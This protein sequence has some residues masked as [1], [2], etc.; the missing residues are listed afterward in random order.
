MKHFNLLF[1]QI[2]LF[3]FLT[4][5]ALYAVSTVDI[6]ISDAQIVEGN[7]GTQNLVFT[8]TKGGNSA[9]TGSVSWKIVD[10][11]TTSDADYINDTGTISDI[12]NIADP[13]I[14]VS[15]KGDTIIEPNETFKVILYNPTDDAKIVDSEGIGTIVDNEDRFYT[16]T[17]SSI[18]VSE[19]AGTIS[20][21]VR[22][23]PAITN[24]DVIKVYYRTV[25][26]T[27]TA[28]G[29][30][31]AISSAIATID[32]S[33]TVNGIT[34]FNVN[35]NIVNDLISESQEYFELVLSNPSITT[36]TSSTV[37]LATDPGTITINDDDGSKAVISIN[38][39][40]VNEGDSG[41]NNM[42]FTISVSQI[43][44]N[45]S[46]SFNYATA[47]VTATSGVDFEYTTGT[48]IIPA[49][50]QSITIPVP[51]IGDF[52]AGEG[53]EELKMVISSASSLVDM[54]KDVGIGTIVDNDS[55]LT[56]SINDASIA[57]TDSDR[58]VNIDVRFSQALTQDLNLTY[59]S[60]DI[61]AN[62]PDDYNGT[63]IPSSV[64]VPAGSLKYTIQYTIVGDDTKEENEEF[65][66]EINATSSEPFVLAR[67][68][69]KVTI[70]DDDNGIGCSSY[71]G[72]MTINEYQN[73]PNYKDDNHPL[74]NNAGM[75]PGNYVEIKYLDFL[76]KQY[77]N[78]LWGV[79][80]HTTAGEHS[81]TWNQRDLSCVDPRYEVFQMNNNVMGKEGYVVLTDQNGN[82]VD[83]LNIANSNHYTQ[84]CHDFVY[85]TDFLSSAQNKDLFREPDGTGDWDDNG[86]GAN[87]G[88]SRCINKDG[89][90]GGLLF[91]IFDAIDTG[92]TPTTPIISGSSVPIMTKI[93]NQA[94][95]L[96]ILSLEP[97]SGF[98][99][100]SEIKVR[101][102]LADGITG[103]RLPGADTVKNP[104]KEVIFNNSSTQPVPNYFYPNAYKN[105]RLRFEYCG[106]DAGAYDDWTEC[107][108][109]DDIISITN[110]RISHSRDNFAI[111]PDHF[112]TTNLD[113]A[114]LKAGSPADLTFS[115]IDGDGTDTV[116]YNESQGTSFDINISVGKRTT[117][118]VPDITMTPAIAF[119]DGT[120]ND[121]F[122][123]NDIGNIHYSIDE[124]VGGEFALVD[125][126]DTLDDSIRLITPKTGTFTLLPD[127]FELQIA[128]KDHNI[129]Q[130]FT[131]L[132]DYLPNDYRMA[133][134]LTAD[135]NVTGAD[136]NITQ[137]YKALCYAQDTNLTLGFESFD[138]THK[139]GGS[140][141]ITLMKYNN[142]TQGVKEQNIT[143]P[144]PQVDITL[145]NLENNTS[146]FTGNGVATI[147][148]NLNFNRDMTNP[149]NPIRIVLNAFD[150][151]LT[152]VNGTRNDTSVN[153]VD[154]VDKV[155]TFFYA[156]ARP[157]KSLYDNVVT[158]SA[159]TPITI[160]S[161]C[162]EGI[163][164]C[165]S[166]YNIDTALGQIDEY[167]WWLS[168]GHNKSLGDGNITLNVN[169]TA[170]NAA[171][172][173]NVNIIAGGIDYNIHVNHT[174][175]TFPY[176]VPI[177]I[178]DSTSDTTNKWL[179]YDEDGTY[180]TP[181]PFYRVRFIIPANWTGTGNTG[182]VVESNASSRKIKKM[183]W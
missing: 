118:P 132:Y 166:N 53:D 7:T 49:G 108:L 19:I 163:A 74:A 83:V 50:V 89:F 135:V 78:D 62:A 84:Q 104:A 16:I 149:V 2:L 139:N 57:E 52:E 96:D 182:L 107:W 4:S 111:R 28:S 9:K 36:T 29:D 155:A 98:L 101:T 82:E 126:D 42:F 1:K 141:R 39:P 171:V 143:L 13:Q 73:N 51:I 180:M 79:A 162:D 134:H 40:S 17:P 127:H 172:D 59:F 151:N 131:Y 94:F 152:D 14:T 65:K 77:V 112:E 120:Y 144:S 100:S 97:S 93:A 140:D 179:I 147:E 114:V 26:Q 8:L 33:N 58:S 154:A 43:Q 178:D 10:V 129:N 67:N 109:N 44:P 170:T 138:I 61:T 88:G 38:D 165:M 117:C 34:D 95:T 175:N 137:N 85:D 177:E 173:T 115:A 27:A 6:S 71:I 161:Y 136:G 181:T 183:D 80:I 11:T 110:R 125:Q 56:L 64:I 15:I 176:T 37:G 46:I 119:Q 3:I 54:G 99:K 167:D 68:L 69:G 24:D 105:V 32:Q 63:S 87:S 21:N 23:D 164:S 174:S 45:D 124:I 113:G 22:I 25:D 41:T 31:T 121:D 92:V 5:S 116:D 156:R 70:F 122:T 150:V 169:P 30:F 128:L 159:Q 76:V 48:A 106:N 133:A 35:I 103:E 75:V 160:L 47:G 86:N 55:G 145:F 146:S 102:Y 12:K 18:I 148:Y 72:L 153:P 60:T 90:P 123:F 81:L 91:T 157:T 66:I 20:A 158:S 142:K 168:L 130:N